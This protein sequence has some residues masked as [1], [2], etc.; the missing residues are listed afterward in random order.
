MVDLGVDVA[1]VHF[2]NPV[3]AAS[4]TFGFGRE[5]EGLYPIDLLG[6]ISLKGMTLKAVSYT[7]LQGRRGCG[8]R[9]DPLRA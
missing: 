4:G 6:G 9:P 3:I 2:K 7:H 5:Y 8:G 1:G